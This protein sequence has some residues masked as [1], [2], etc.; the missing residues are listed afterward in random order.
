MTSYKELLAQREALDKQIADAREVEISAAIAKAR[1]LIA[2]YGLNEGDVFAKKASRA[3]TPT[4]TVA[5]KYRDPAT[6]AIWTGRGKPPRWI[7][8]QDRAQF[9]I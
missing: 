5:P 2:Q 7:A 3:G 4:G 6:G 1:E 8:G 9:A